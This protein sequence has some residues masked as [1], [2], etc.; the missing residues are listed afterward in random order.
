MSPLGRFPGGELVEQGLAD[1]RRG[2][3]SSHALLVAIGGPRLRRLGLPVPPAESLPPEPELRL[4]RLIGE[5]QPQGTHSAYN[6]LIRRLIG[7]EQALEHACAR[8]RRLAR[9]R[10]GEGASGGGG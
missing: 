1:L 7:F 4:Y 5:S 3:I 9:G 10:P 6:A 2:E 8:D